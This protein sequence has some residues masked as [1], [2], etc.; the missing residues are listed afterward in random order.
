MQVL[1]IV[2]KITKMK[3]LSMSALKQSQTWLRE[4]N[5]ASSPIMSPFLGDSSAVRGVNV[6]LRLLGLISVDSS[7]RILLVTGLFTE[8]D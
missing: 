6:S 1:T 5:S 7:Y 8:I 3:I 4:T 2:T